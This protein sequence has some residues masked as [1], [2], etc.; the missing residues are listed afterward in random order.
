MSCTSPIRNGRFEISTSG[1]E[2][3]ES[4]PGVPLGWYK[5]TVRVNMPG[6]KP[7]FP[8]QPAID[9][10]PIYFSAEKNAVIK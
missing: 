8:G 2:R 5:V 10:N 7:I 1:V 9:V 3:S 6:E 4:G